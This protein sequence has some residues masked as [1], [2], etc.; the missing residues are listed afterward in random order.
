MPELAAGFA[1]GIGFAIL[2]S[3][4]HIYLLLRDYT[5]LKYQNICQNLSMDQKFW[6]LNAADFLSVGHDNWQEELQRDRKKAL[7]SALI[8]SSLM[9]FLSWFG[10][11]FSLLYIL[12]SRW[13]A[14]SR[15]EKKL[16]NSKLAHEKITDIESLRDL[17]CQIS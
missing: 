10:F 2:L 11:F 15:V 17:V 14:K 16:F 4:L 6:S 9:C 3:A 13:L 7:K 8:F 1:M 5:S 12:S